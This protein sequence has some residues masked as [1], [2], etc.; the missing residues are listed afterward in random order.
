MDGRAASFDSTRWSIVLAAAR[1]PSERARAALSDLCETYWYPVY[2][3]VRRRG[4]APDEA[5]DLTQ[6][7]FAKLLEKRYVRDADPERGRFRSFLLAAVKHFL[8]NER[9]RVEALKRG[10]GRPLVSLDLETAEGRYRV[11]PS[12]DVTPE[13]VYERRWALTL[14]DRTLARLRAE[15]E[16]A[17]Q[18]PRFERLKG[19]LTGEA[20]GGYAEAMAALGLSEGAVK[21]AVHRLR[22]RYRELLRAEIAETV[23]DASAVEGE[24]RALFAALGG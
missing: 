14:L 5:E 7:F 8:S 22:R 20:S 24:L 1:D 15:Y 6:A 10:G 13:R 17:G 19:Y 23:E 11:E 2:A 18:A 9:D 12:H 3:Y 16:R 21:V 4:H